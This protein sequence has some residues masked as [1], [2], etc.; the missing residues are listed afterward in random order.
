[1]CTGSQGALGR[2]VW[3]VLEGAELRRALPPGRTGNPSLPSSRPALTLPLPASTPR[4]LGFP[5]SRH[6]VS[7]VTFK[8]T[9]TDLWCS[10]EIFAGEEGMD[11]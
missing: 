9:G 10:F 1:M 3:R 6:S 11:S 4:S 8:L 5:L 2:R 7:L